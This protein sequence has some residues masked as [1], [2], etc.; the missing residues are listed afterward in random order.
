MTL[1]V[2]FHRSAWAE[3]NQAHRYYEKK[4]PGLGE[5]FSARVHETLDRIAAIPTLHQ[6]VH[7]D[8]RRAVV[9]DFPYSV[10]YRFNSKQIRVVSVFHGKRDPSI[11]QRRS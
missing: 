6:C 8:V 1:P 4:R 5:D 2:V 3:F 10:M 11:W 9:R 7:R